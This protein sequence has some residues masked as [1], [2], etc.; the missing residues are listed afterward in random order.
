MS[1]KFPQRS[2]GKLNT[3]N[4][5][6][7]T[8]GQWQRLTF[9]PLQNFSGTI[10]KFGKFTEKLSCANYWARFT[11]AQETLRCPFCATTV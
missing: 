11:I 6:Q 5:K 2:Q 7:K 1:V 4:I 8:G 10:S 3:F 9:R